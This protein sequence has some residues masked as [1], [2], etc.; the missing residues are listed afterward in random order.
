MFVLLTF[1]HLFQW[2]AVFI[3]TNMMIDILVISYDP[4]TVGLIN[5]VNSS[6]FTESLCLQLQM[7]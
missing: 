7:I 1:L 3:I 2:M 4:S 5:I 6:S